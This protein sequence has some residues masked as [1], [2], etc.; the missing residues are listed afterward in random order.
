MKNQ[1]LFDFIKGIVAKLFFAGFCRMPLS[2]LQISQMLLDILQN[3][4]PTHIGV[5]FDTKEPTPR[6]KIFPQY[7]AQR[8]AMRTQQDALQAPLVALQD[9]V[10]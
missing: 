7:K 8:D 9:F 10:G 5:A 6:H 4:S 2:L 3:H 1:Q